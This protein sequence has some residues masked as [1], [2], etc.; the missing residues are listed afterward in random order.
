MEYTVQDISVNYPTRRSSSFMDDAHG[1]KPRAEVVF[2]I[3]DESRHAVES[4]SHWVAP[5]VAR[6]FEHDL[7][8]LP[9]SYEYGCDCLSALEKRICLIVLTEMLGRRDYGTQEA[10]R[11]L[12]Q[13]GFRTTAIEDAINRSVELRF[14]DESRFMRSFIEER[15]R[16]GWGKRKIEAE[17]RQRGCDPSQLEGYPERYFNE[18]SDYEH[19]RALLERKSIPEH[20]AFER[21][22]RHLMNKGF[23]YSI[24]AR[25]VRARIDGLEDE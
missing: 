23:T 25:A 6:A 2:S 12:V 5:R 21:L 13:A 10:K 18:D 8:T 9:C 15:L 7:P 4:R 24:A 3:E 22:V 11:K 20:N 16:R 1:V 14:L 19:A 17:L